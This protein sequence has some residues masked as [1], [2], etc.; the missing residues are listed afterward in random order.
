MLHD[1]CR[2]AK[3]FGAAG[4]CCCFEVMSLSHRH[5][6]RSSFVTGGLGFGMRHS[7]DDFKFV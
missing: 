7:D 1:E 5:D 3:A 2:L 4:Y 6:L